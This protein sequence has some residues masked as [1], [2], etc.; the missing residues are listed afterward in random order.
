LN[1]D[2]L[3]ADFTAA[4]NMLVGKDKGATVLSLSPRGRSNLIGYNNVPDG[5][6]KVY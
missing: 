6:W 3:T 5:S 2:T 1:S 4:F